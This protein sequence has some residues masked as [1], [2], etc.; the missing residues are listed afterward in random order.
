M[1]VH[2]GFWRLF[3]HLVVCAV[4]SSSSAHPL[5]A[6]SPHLS[7]TMNN[8]QFEVDPRIRA[9]NGTRQVA[10]KH[11]SRGGNPYSDDM[12]RQVLEM[13]LNGFDLD[14][15][16]L[17]ALREE[18]KFPCLDTCRNWIDIFYETGDILPKRATGNNHAER[19]IQGEVL[20]QLALYRCVNPKATLAECRAY[21]YNIDPT[22]DPYSNSQ[23]HRAEELLG[24]K[25]KAAS[26]TA[27]LAYTPTNQLK[28]ELYWTMP[29]PLGMVGVDIS[30]IID[31]DEAGFK[32]EHSNRSFGK[33]VSALRCTQNGVYGRGE[34]LNLLL[35]ICG[36]DIDNMRWHETWMDGG[37]T[38][39]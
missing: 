26:T 15:P 21:L 8:Q 35:A 39:E 24:L 6:S 22:V 37:T 9:P 4:L 31:I 25:R 20:E 34:K 38:I 36:D 5:I 2:R 18:Y 29:P 28:R 17:N 32:L 33:T 7:F 1:A 23:V 30:D 13:H 12:R 27:D 11:P 14:T 10:P 16:E 3:I 19:E